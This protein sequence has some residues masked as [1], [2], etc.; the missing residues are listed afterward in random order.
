MPPLT[1]P[2]LRRAVSYPTGTPLVEALLKDAE[3]AVAAFASPEIEA[4]EITHPPKRDRRFESIS[5]QPSSGESDEL[6]T[7]RRGRRSGRCG[8]P[9]MAGVE[10]VL[11]PV[12]HHRSRLVGDVQQA[13]DP[14]Q[15]V[16]VSR[17]EITEPADRFYRRRDFA[18]FGGSVRT[19]PTARSSQSRN[20]RSSA[21]GG[22]TNT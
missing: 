9:P 14:P 7:K 20:P 13:F 10:D 19:K 21:G 1:Y 4:T 15:P 3:P 2:R 5:L 8:S 6:P 11:E 16:T 22:S 17:P 18:A 12:D